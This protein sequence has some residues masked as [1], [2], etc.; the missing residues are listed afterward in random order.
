MTEN[1]ETL[2]I[3]ANVEITA[4]ALKA[5]VDNAKKISGADEQGVYRIDTADKV[6]EMISRF[7]LEH[8]FESYVK[9][10]DNYRP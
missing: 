6:S 8:D 5:V 3:R 7:L 4:D 10:V 2:I 9:N 1:K